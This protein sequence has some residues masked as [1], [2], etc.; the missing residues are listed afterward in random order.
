MSFPT[1]PESKSAVKKAGKAIAENRETREDIEVVDQWRA[2]HGYVLNTFKVWLRGNLK[3]TKSNAEFAQRLKRRNTVID[4]LRRICPDG[5]PLIRDV[6]SMQ[7]FAGCRL[8]FDTVKELEDFRTHLLS[9]RVMSNVHH[10]LKHEDHDKY[11]YISRPKTS[12]YRGI[13]YVFYH[14]PRSHRANMTKSKPWHN[15]MVEVQFRTRVQ[16]AWATALEI[17][18]I[19]DGTRTKFEHGE[20]KRG[21]LFSIASEI[22]A[23]EQEGLENAFA[24]KTTAALVEEFRKLEEELSVVQTL[25]TMREFEDYNKLQRHNVLNIYRDEFGSTKLEVIPFKNAQEALERANQLEEDP[26]SYNAVYVTSD[27]PQQ[28]RSAYRNYFRDPV[29]F[30]EIL[31]RSLANY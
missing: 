30:V 11:N 24:D 14:V 1:P 12:G 31:E 13:H 26:S 20:N 16:H 28:L 6:T 7:D 29:A 18:D 8:I 4:K 27:N 2:A 19:V 9:N 15:L 10:K 17:A 22:I 3:I 23:R 25:K 5:N 21:H